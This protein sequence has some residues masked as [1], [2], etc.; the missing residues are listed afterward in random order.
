MPITWSH[1]NYV[2]LLAAILAAHPEFKPDCKTVA[3]Y[4]GDG[5]TYDA[6]QGCLK[7]IR[8]KAQ[9]LRQEVESGMRPSTP[10]KPTPK[11]RHAAG[12]P[13]SKKGKIYQ[14]DEVD[15]EEFITPVKKKARMVDSATPTPIKTKGLGEKR[16]RSGSAKGSSAPPVIDLLDS[17]DDSDDNDLCSMKIKHEAPVAVKFESTPKASKLVTSMSS[18]Y[19]SEDDYNE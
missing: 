16:A 1:E 13:S 2:K 17:D 7:P 15:D 14:D 3:V 19:D 8:K 11:K 18:Y 10:A 4:F 6:I 9:Q 12:T 5:A